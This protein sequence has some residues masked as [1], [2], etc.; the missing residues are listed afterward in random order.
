MGR[1]RRVSPRALCQGRRDRAAWPRFSGRIWR[2]RRRPVHEDR[3]LA[4]TGARRRRRGQRQP[5][6][7]H[8]RLAA[9][10][11]RRAPRDQGAGAAGGAVG[12]EDL[13]AGDHRAERRLRRRQSAHQGAARRRPLRRQRRE[14]LHHLGH[15]RRLSDRRGA[16]RRRG[17]RRRQPAADRGRHAGPVAHEAQ[18]DGLVGVGH[19]DACISTSAGCRPRT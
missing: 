17:R 18:E 1:G 16:H 7:P 10:R 9:D 4:G 5:D 19:R 14:D 13:R 11:A 15:A 2:R 3:G 6:E 12:Q 8:H